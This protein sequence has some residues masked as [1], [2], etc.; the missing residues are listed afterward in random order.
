M[1]LALSACG[2]IWDSGGN[3]HALGIGYITW[4]LPPPDTSAY[5]SGVDIV[6]SAVL[7]TSMATGI[8]VGYARERTVKLSGDRFVTLDCLDCDL[9]NAHPLAGA[10]AREAR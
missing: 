6:G 2:I 4:P 10:V 9:A 1:A 5:V 3:R 7:A 8:T